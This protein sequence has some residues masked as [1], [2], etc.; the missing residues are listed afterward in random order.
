MELGIL[1]DSTCDLP[2]HLR[3][4][5]GIEVVPAILVIDG[6]S[7]ADGRDISREEFYTRLPQMKTA[8]TTAMP[9]PG[10]FAAAMGRLF[11]RG[12]THILALHAA[13]AL[14]GIINGARLAAADFAEQVTIYDSASLTLGLG[15]QVLAAAEAAAEGAGAD[16][17]LAAARSV[18][19]R[20][21]IRAALDTIEYV[22]RSGRVPSA[23]A[24]LGGLLKIKPFIELEEGQV[25]TIG[26]VRTTQ[27]GSE[28]VFDGLCSL[29]ELERL[30]ILHTNAEGRARSLL[31]QLMQERRMSLPR[32][33]LIVNVTT[34]IGT[35]VGPNG[36]GFAAV[37]RR[38]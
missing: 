5:Y 19:A 30:A 28:K 7:H 3:A 11:E 27:Q 32:E 8:P 14:T 24:S 6:E 16:E 37:T 31:D 22:R 18:R 36:L 4:Q 10:E 21:T 13:E 15:F 29:G 25:R 17:A 12:C 1:T 38:A 20:T 23:V 2:E 34:A 33:I 35:H 9:S 26:A